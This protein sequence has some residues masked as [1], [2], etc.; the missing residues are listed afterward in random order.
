MKIYLAGANAVDST[1]THWR[2]QL[3][4]SA[5]ENVKTG[6]W[7]PTQKAILG[8]YHYTGPFVFGAG[9]HS[10][11]DLRSAAIRSSD[12][13][14]TWLPSSMA[15]YELGVA[16]GFGVRTVAAAPPGF[17]ETTSC[18][19]MVD[20]QVSALAPSSALIEA[21]KYVKNSGHFFNGVW[22]RMVGKWGSACHICGGHTEVGE[23][24]MWRRKDDAAKGGD[25]C[26]L[27]CFVLN[28]PAR[29]MDKDLQAVGMEL[30]RN[31]V[32]KLEE[33][34]SRLVET[35]QDLA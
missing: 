1:R 21:I 14:F 19:D 26:H 33:E 35:I 15:L 22:R 23:N 16:R 18:Q 2:Y 24:I 9:Q 8:A 30:L 3:T 29:V 17:W 32:R 7:E 12:L 11:S 28:A 31:R 25:V 27:E 34:N 6:Y 5:C 20:Y 13:V 4:V 10:A